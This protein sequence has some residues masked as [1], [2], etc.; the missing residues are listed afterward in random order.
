MS[1]VKKVIVNSLGFPPNKKIWWSGYPLNLFC[2]KFRLNYIINR[3]KKDI[4]SIP[5]PR[6]VQN[7]YSFQIFFIKQLMS[8]IHLLKSYSVKILIR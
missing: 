2:A 5:K 7:H 4:A 3:A 1:G 6:K 8:I